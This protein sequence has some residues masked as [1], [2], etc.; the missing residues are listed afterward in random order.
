VESGRLPSV[1]ADIMRRKA[2]DFV[3][4]NVSVGGRVVRQDVPEESEE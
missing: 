4:D 1:A 2:L 3:V